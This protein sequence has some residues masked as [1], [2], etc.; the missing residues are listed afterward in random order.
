M[1]AFSQ[2]V[3]GLL[4]VLSVYC[5][6]VFRFLTPR[7]VV[8]LQECDPRFVRAFR[9]ICPNLYHDTVLTGPS[10]ASPSTDLSR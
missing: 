1:C 9:Q 8:G 2:F 6:R 3:Q 5:V 4:N 7:L 10:W